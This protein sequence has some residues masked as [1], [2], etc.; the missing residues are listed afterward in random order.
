MFY[1]IIIKLNKKNHNIT[2]YINKNYN[3]KYIN[4]IIK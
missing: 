2:L 1:L 3:S 4:Y